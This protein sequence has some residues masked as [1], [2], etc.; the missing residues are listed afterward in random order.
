MFLSTSRVALTSRP[1]EAPDRV[2]QDR[3]DPS[4]INLTG[5][6]I[7]EPGGA[8]LEIAPH[9][10]GLAYVS[11]TTMTP[12]GPVYVHFEASRPSLVVEVPT[13]A[14]CSLVLPEEFDG[15]VAVLGDG[16]DVDSHV[17]LGPGRH[18]IDAKAL[19]SPPSTTRA[20]RHPSS[21]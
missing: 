18:E 13:G 20:M 6:R 14:E 16:T 9:P 1:R 10:A 4:R 12:R 8:V 17:T 21:G 7:L 3:A 2:V 19:A 5:V 15:L 11:G